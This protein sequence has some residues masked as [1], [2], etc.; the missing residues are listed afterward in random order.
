MRNLRNTL[1]AL[2]ATVAFSS[3]CDSSKTLYNGKID[4]ANVSY[5]QTFDNLGDLTS[6]TMSIKKAEG[7]SIDLTDNS[8]YPADY[9][10]DKVK[11]TKNGKTTEY[12]SR[13]VA[14]SAMIEEGQKKFNEYKSRIQEEKPKEDLEFLRNF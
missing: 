12:L 5:V 14:D 11:I 7:G 4:D 10:I 2:L 3:G 9:Q 8:P 1:C 13:N 6:Q